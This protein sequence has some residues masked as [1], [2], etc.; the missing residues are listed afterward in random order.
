MGKVIN[1]FFIARLNCSL[2]KIHETVEISFELTDY[3]VP[4]SFFPLLKGG[5]T[6]TAKVIQDLFPK[7]SASWLYILSLNY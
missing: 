4:L 6:V 2:M 5:F 7:S 3:S 1:M